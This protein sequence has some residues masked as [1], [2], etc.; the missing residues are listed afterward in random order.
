MP[1]IKEINS[2]SKT[3]EELVLIS[4]LSGY[5][6]NVKKYL[7]KQL[8]NKSLNYSGD[9]LGNLISTIKGDEKLPSVILFAHMD[10]L[11][12][13]VKKI[14]NNGFIRVERVGGVPEKALVSQ[15]I[16]I[17]N[18]KNELIKGIIGNKSHHA[19]Q[20]DEK[21][22]VTTIKNMYI[23]A[24]FK[25]KRDV[26]KNGISIG[27]PVTYA[28]FYKTLSNHN[29]CGSS[30]DDRAGCAVLLNV[31]STLVQVKKKPTVH[32]VF[33]VQEEFN[34]RGVLPVI[35]SLKPDIAI[36][37]D[38]TLTSDTPD[39]KGSS[40]IFLGS[41][42]CIS[43]FSFHGRGTLNG[44]IPHP[45]LVEI[46]EKAAKAK[47]INL[48]RSAASGILTDSSYVQF[49]NNGIA[50][51][52]IGFPM[53]YSHSS[54]EVCNLNDLIDLKNLILTAITKVDKNFKLTR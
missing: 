53:R 32:I 2:I 37:V 18:N 46:F 8:K 25:N 9:V 4:G 45:S 44:V 50:T 10:Q 14:E 41:G 6:A 49:A 22:T 35:N 3:L 13:V 51:I 28:P 29:V 33:T 23:D 48:Q 17:V 7:S 39:M 43:L 5:E 15:D 1:S 47:K 52:D 36:Q 20:P 12:F 42:P 54:R 34:L 11:G 31:A 16:V 38:L 21:Y 27:S 19:T 40:D 30:L 24:G 26:L